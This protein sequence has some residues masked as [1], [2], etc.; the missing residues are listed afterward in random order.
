MAKKTR[1]PKDTYEV[2]ELF[3]CGEGHFLTPGFTHWESGEACPHGHSPGASNADVHLYYRK[4]W[5]PV[6]RGTKKN[7]YSRLRGKTV[8][9]FAKN[10]GKW[11]HLPV[12]QPGEHDA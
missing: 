4:L 2:V 12:V 8:A 3:A 9:N 11:G 10:P 1:D 5:V 7:P 6:W